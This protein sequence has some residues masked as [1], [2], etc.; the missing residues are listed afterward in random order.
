M[1]EIRSR[2]IA[3]ARKP[4]SADVAAFI[5]ARNFGRWQKLLNF[6]HEDYPDVFVPEW[7]YAGKKYGWGMRLRKS[8]S[9]C[10]FIPERNRLKLLI[11][12]GREER[13][14]AESILTELTSHVRQDYVNAKTYHDGRW[15]GI[16]INSNRVLKDVRR[17]LRVKRAPKRTRSDLRDRVFEK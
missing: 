13:A 12:F 4:T 10:T 11:V 2:L 15:V 5:G 9:F 1:S 6:I 14:K 3:G 17:L 8:K 7:L 16:I